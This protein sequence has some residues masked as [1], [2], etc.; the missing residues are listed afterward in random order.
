MRADPH[1]PASAGQG[2]AAGAS[3]RYALYYVPPKDHALTRRAAEWF[4]RDPFT[5]EDIE[6]P[7]LDAMDPVRIAF[8][9]A[10]PRR[11][12]FHATLKAPFRLVEGATEADLVAEA[13]AFA[14]RTPPFS[15]QRL[16]I[17]RLKNFFA[18]RPSETEAELD[19]MAGDVVGTFEPFRAP[20]SDAEIERRSETLSGRVELGNLQRWGYPYVFDTFRFHMT[21][22]GPVAEKDFEEVSRALDEQFSKALSVPIPVAGL[23]LCVEPEPNAPFR[24]HSYFAFSQDG[25][26]TRA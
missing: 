15:I 19:R 21:L 9:R 26:T 17:K 4:G 20:L 3:W 25:T 16:E 12:G 2:P 23:A 22:T 24:M 18:L 13:A 11:Y 8:F 7:A 5:G 14:A 6:T 1:Q 10:V